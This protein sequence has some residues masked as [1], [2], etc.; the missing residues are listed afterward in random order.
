ML[1]RITNSTHFTLTKTTTTNFAH[2]GPSRLYFGPYQRRVIKRLF[3]MF[4][5]WKINECVGE[6]SVIRPVKWGFSLYS[7]NS[8]DR[9]RLSFADLTGPLGAVPQEAY[10][11]NGKLE[12]RSANRPIPQDYRH[13]KYSENRRFGLAVT[14]PNSSADNRS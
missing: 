10:G 2:H 12:G 9:N 11:I 5:G 3:T 13:P 7:A 8:I 1:A 4:V 14:R 6:R